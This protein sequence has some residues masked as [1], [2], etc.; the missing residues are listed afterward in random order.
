MGDGSFWPTSS[1]SI[2]CVFLVLIGFLVGGGSSR[3][4]VGRCRFGR[5]PYVCAMHCSMRL[6]DWRCGWSAVVW[7]ATIDA[8]EVWFGF[9]EAFEN[10]ILAT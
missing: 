9:E 1:K 4:I 2:V 8:L 3:Y 5:L 7:L 6:G 10:F